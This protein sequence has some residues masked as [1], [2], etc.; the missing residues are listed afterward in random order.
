MSDSKDGSSDSKFYYN[1][2]TGQVERGLTSDWNNSMGPYDSHEQALAALQTA[3]E[4]NL[5]WEAEDERE[6]A[7]EEGDADDR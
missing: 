7:W 3:R 5:Q 1:L 6:R 4:R 2:S